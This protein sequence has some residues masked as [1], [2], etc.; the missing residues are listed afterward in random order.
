MTMQTRKYLDIY[1][2]QLNGLVCLVCLNLVSKPTV[3]WDIRIIVSVS[4]YVA[5]D[6]TLPQNTM[7]TR[8]ILHAHFSR[9]KAYIKI[10]WT[11]GT[12][13]RRKAT[14]TCTSHMSRSVRNCTRRPASQPARETDTQNSPRRWP[15]GKCKIHVNGKAKVRI[16]CDCR[17]Y[18]FRYNIYSWSNRYNMTARANRT[19][20]IWSVRSV[21]LSFIIYAYVRF[22]GYWTH[23]NDACL[24]SPKN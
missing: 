19:K 22:F 14:V 12:C 17:G 7:I 13:L 8:N 16:W 15:S 23:L 6:E 2:P 9:S 1:I 24:H 4:S 3:V 5:P 10:R 21:V 20:E 18:V 11:V